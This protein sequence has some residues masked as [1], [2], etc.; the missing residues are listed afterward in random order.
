MTTLGVD[1]GETTGIALVDDR[2]HIIEAWSPVGF[3]ATCD[4]IRAIISSR[5]E[6]NTI[7]SEQFVFLTKVPPTARIVLRIEGAIQYLAWQYSRAIVFQQPDE[8]S[9]FRPLANARAF[10]FLGPYPIP[11]HRRHIIDAYAHVLRHFR[12]KP[13]R[14]EVELI[15]KHIYKNGNGGA[16]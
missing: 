11:E 3:E 13:T 6:L 10:E 2:L 15:E 16:S 8:R 14:K 9:A 1:P 5:P 4:A 7:V 12:A